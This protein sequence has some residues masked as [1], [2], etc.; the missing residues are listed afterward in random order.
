MNHNIR[1]QHHQEPESTTKVISTENTKEA[2][3]NDNTVVNLRIEKPTLIILAL[4][5]ALSAIVYFFL[6]KRRKRV[7]FG[8]RGFR[9][10]ES[11]VEEE[12]DLLI[13]QM[14]H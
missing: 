13:S 3:K 6:K 12:D 7:N 14:Y 11:L 10:G 1:V 5:V 2:R 4:V 9:R 8:V